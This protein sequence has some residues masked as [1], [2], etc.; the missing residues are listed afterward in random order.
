MSREARYFT[1]TTGEQSV[2][3]IIIFQEIKQ[4]IFT[5]QGSHAIFSDVWYFPK[6]FIP[7]GN[8]PSGNFQTVEFPK[9]QFPKS[10]L[11]LTYGS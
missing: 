11:D 5:Q 6:G 10:G 3:K 2:Y 9:R 1:S 8:L 7:I 4:Y